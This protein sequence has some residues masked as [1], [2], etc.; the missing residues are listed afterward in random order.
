V[1]D[2]QGQVG[3]LNTN[4][5]TFQG[6]F[7]AKG[8]ETLDASYGDLRTLSGSF[9]IMP[10]FSL[11]FSGNFDAHAYGT[12][13]VDKASLTGSANITLDG[14]LIIM[15][16]TPMTMQGNSQLT[17]GENAL[18][19]PAGLKFSNHYVPLPQTYDEVKSIN[20]VR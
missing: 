19:F 15:G 20:P 4:T 8:V 18:G 13:V 17:A 7:T 1:T 2:T 3:N 9:M 12:I 5:I 6:G 11:S 10:G 16:D 14:S